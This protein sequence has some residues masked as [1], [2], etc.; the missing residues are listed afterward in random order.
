[1]WG[2]FKSATPKSLVA[3]LHVLEKGVFKSA[4]P[5]SLTSE[6]H[7]RSDNDCNFSGTGNGRG[8]RRKTSSTSKQVVPAF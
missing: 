1:M 3:K 8:R 2:V 7:V 6:L 5:K 4:T